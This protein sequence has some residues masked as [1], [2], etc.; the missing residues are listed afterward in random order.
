MES[1]REEIRKEIKGV[2]REESIEEE[3][4]KMKERVDQIFGKMERSR[5]ENNMRMVGRRM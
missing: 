3:W 2:G 1:R 4:N 5:S